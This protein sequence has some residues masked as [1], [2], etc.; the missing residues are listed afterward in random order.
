MRCSAA[1][2][3]SAVDQLEELREL[4]GRAGSQK[5]TCCG[6]LVP[7]PTPKDAQMLGTKIGAALDFAKGIV[8]KPQ[9][10]T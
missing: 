5:C 10:N 6:Q 3:H 7:E 1:Y 9:D 4:L 8:W 2:M